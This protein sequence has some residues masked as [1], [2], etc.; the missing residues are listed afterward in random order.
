MYLFNVFATKLRNNRNSSAHEP[1][2]SIKEYRFS[3]PEK[4]RRQ[5]SDRNFSSLPDTRPL[6]FQIPENAYETELR[7]IPKY[8]FNRLRDMGI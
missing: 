6:L 7:T 2:I 5:E 1:L 4:V 3:H 8:F